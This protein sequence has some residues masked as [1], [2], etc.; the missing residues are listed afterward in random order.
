MLEE[1]IEVIRELWKGEKLSHTGEHFT[2][3]NAK[4]YDTPLS[5]VPVIIAA[6]GA[7]AAEAA[8]ES[9]TVWSSRPATRNLMLRLPRR[10]GAA[11]R[12]TDR[13]PSA[14]AKDELAKQDA[15]KEIWPTGAIEGMRPGVATAPPLRA[16]DESVTEDQLAEHTPCGPDIDRHSRRCSSTSR[17]GR[18][19]TSTSTRW[20]RTRRTSPRRLRQ[21]VPAAETAAAPEPRGGSPQRRLPADRRLRWATGLR[22][23]SRWRGIRHCRCA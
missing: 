11:S 14:G 12:S 18:R 20:A 13:R 5:K 7:K 9:A 8:D 21:D 19:T 17:R 4:I 10:G 6:S 2:V 1:A 15:P 22:N 16:A 3:D 23:Y